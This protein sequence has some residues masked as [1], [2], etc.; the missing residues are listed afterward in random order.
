M[1]YYCSG[2]Y[3]EQRQTKFYREPWDT[4]PGNKKLK[5]E[6]QL[7]KQYLIDPYTFAQGQKTILIDP[8]TEAE[9]LNKLQFKLRQKI[10]K[11]GI[12]VEINPSS[13]LLIGNMADLKDHPLWRLN[14]PQ[15]E[16]DLPPISVC[17]GSDD[18]LT[19]ATSTREEYQIVYDTL[20]LSGLTDAQARSWL[21]DA[22]EAGL[23]SRFTFAHNRSPEFVWRPA[24]ETK[25]I[26]DQF[27]EKIIQ[28]PKGI[29]APIMQEDWS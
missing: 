26:I 27:Y 17:I 11:L 10:G 14:P 15:H 12:T 21:E 3:T 25:E 5:P 24:Y 4:S 6:Q 23:N 9:V 28:P 1:G 29:E 16:S 20:T 19:F 2:I 7:L 22:R 18:P 8:S 13:N